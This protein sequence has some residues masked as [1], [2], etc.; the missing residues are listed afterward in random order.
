M[1]CDHQQHCSEVSQQVTLLKDHESV[2]LVLVNTALS[3]AW[4]KIAISECP[5]WNSYMVGT[6]L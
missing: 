4:L 3:Q 5:Q 1:V 2:G 6:I